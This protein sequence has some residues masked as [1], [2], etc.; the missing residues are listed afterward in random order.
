M[1]RRG[2]SRTGKN[3]F[4]LTCSC[5]KKLHAAQLKSASAR[6]SR[7]S[8]RKK[9]FA[10]P[11]V[12]SFSLFSFQLFFMDGTT[13][14]RKQM[15]HNQQFPENTNVFFWFTKTNLVATLFVVFHIIRKNANK[16]EP[17]SFKKHP[18]LN[19]NCFH[20]KSIAIWLTRRLCVCC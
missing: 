12:I 10:V 13:T 17:L 15:P 14:A 6:I 9:I 18:F 2:M 11:A 8:E 5:S 20:V 3:E 4:I 7:F 1:K 19:W 16:F